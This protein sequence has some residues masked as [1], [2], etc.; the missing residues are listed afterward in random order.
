[1]ENE[2]EKNLCE[3]MLSE[4]ML[5]EKISGEKLIDWI[6][7]LGKLFYQFEKYS[8]TFI[9]R[10]LEKLTNLKYFDSDRL[11]CFKMIHFFL[12]R[13]IETH[14]FIELFRLIDCDK[15]CENV[16]N[17]SIIETIIDT[18]NFENN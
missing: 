7:L 14:C 18:R 15:I 2:Y 16:N 4:K 13:K 9:Y 6:K 5:N 8:N 1:M 12:E 10:K 11:I 3:E 17:L